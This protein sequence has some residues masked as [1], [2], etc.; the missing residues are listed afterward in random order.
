MNMCNEHYMYVSHIYI[1]LCNTFS[2][3]PGYSEL[4]M[5][6]RILLLY[7]LQRNENPCEK[8]W[9]PCNESKLQLMFYSCSCLYLEVFCFFFGLVMTQNN[10]MVRLQQCRRFEE[11][12]VPLDYYHSR[13]YYGLE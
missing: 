10:L 12:R 4:P 5:W 3:S 1:W 13:F 11:C 2:S 7:P 8:K 9:F 6:I